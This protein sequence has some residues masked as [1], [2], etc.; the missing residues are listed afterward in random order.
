MGSYLSEPIR[1]K[2]TETGENRQIKYASCE[3]QGWRSTMEDAKIVNLSLDSESML[4]G[5]F[6]GHEGN[7]V[8]EFVSRHFCQELL[9]NKFY[10]RGNYE[11]ALKENFLRMDELLRSPDGIKE[12]IRISRNLSNDHEVEAD[13]SLIV[14]GCTSIVALI[15]RNTIYVANAG[16]SRCVLSRGGKA[17][18]L[19]QDHKPNLPEETD[20]ILK[21]GGTISSDGRVMGNLNLSRC[22]GDLQFKNNESIPQKDQ[23]ITA[24]PGIKI[25]AITAKDQ[26]LILACDGV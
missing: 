5:V 26:F 13:S 2:K 18:D 11:E 3:M 22:I 21:A 14:A 7:E 6:D 19:S 20:R 8:A 1:T 15:H 16:D 24:Y 23:M 25:E 4:F 12:V 9:R 10:Q 17:I